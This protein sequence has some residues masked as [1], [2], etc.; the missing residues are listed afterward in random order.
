M[1]RNNLFPIFLKTDQLHILIVGGGS[2]AEEKLHFLTESSPDA[3]V[4]IVAPM[5]HE[6]T[7][8]LAKA[9]NVELTYDQYNTSHLYGVHMVFATT[10]SPE[11]NAQVYNDCRKLNI[12][13]NVAGDIP[14]CDFYVGGVVTKGLVKIGISTNGKLPTIAKRLRQFF[15]EAIPDDIIKMLQNLN[16]KQK[17]KK[18][19][20]E[21]KT[22]KINKITKELFEKT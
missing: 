5:F 14:Y 10:D 12:L 15:E 9:F 16:T 19:D 18:G 8:A 1:D 20:F 11:V 7:M 21:E 6:G 4:T 3:K 22:D 13:V 2:L 17:T